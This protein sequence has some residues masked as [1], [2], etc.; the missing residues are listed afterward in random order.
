MKW[1]ILLAS[2]MFP[3]LC[4]AEVTTNSD[5]PLLDA[6]I[7]VEQF[8]LRYSE[9]NP[10]MTQA[11]KEADMLSRTAHESPEQYQA[12]ILERLQDAQAE[13][14]RLSLRYNE[15]HPKMMMVEHLMLFLQG[16]LDRAKVAGV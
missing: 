2:L 13:K 10:R 4:N 7:Q 6:R 14:A 9:K 1:V 12:H 8:H 5:D 3:L 11:E 15:K 16:E